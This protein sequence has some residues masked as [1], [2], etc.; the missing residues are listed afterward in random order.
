MIPGSKSTADIRQEFIYFFSSKG[1]NVIA[2]SS[3]VPDNDP[4][5]LFTNAGMNQFKDVFLGRDKRSYQRATTSQGC[6]RAGGKHN[7]L[8]NVGYTARHHTFFEMLGNFSFG[9][10]FK[11]DA[12]QFAWELLTGDK[13]FNL[14]SEK[15]WVTVYAADEE[16]YNIWTNDVGVSHE[17]ILRIGDNKGS[18]YA[19]DNFWHMG[20]TGPCGPCSEI[21]YDHGDNICGG[22]PGSMEDNGDRYVEIWNLVFTQFNRQAD[23]TLLPLR[24]PSVDTGMGLERIASVIQRVHSNYDIDLFRQLI[25]AIAEVTGAT[26]MNSQSLRVIADH[27]RSCA[28]IVSEGVVPSNEGR[29]YVLRRIIRRALRHG[30]MLGARDTFFY[31]IV[32]PLIEV[33][34][35]ATDQLKLN[36]LKLKKSMVEQV[37]RTEEKQFARTLE[38]G[39]ALLVHHE[40]GKVTGDTLD[41]EAAFRLHDTYGLPL[42]I[43][44]DVCR[45][46]NIKVDKAS[47]ERAMDTQRKRAIESRSFSAAYNMFLGLDQATHFF[48]YELVTHPGQVIALF[49]DGQ[50]VEGIHQ[51]EKAIVVL[52]DTPFY[53]ESGGQVGDR[54]EMKAA[55]GVFRVVDTLQDGKVF[56]HLGML[57]YGEFKVG[58]Q[59]SAH[60]DQA[61]RYRI[62]INHSATHLL[63]TALLQ[64]L[65]E[66][67]RIKASI[68]YELYLRVE[69]SYHQD[70][71]HDNILKL[72]DIVNKQIRRN[73]PIMTE[74]IA[75][76]ICYMQLYNYSDKV[77]VLNIGEF[78]SELCCGTHAS[79]TGDLGFFCILYEESISNGI[80]R[81]EAIT[82]EVALA[83]LHQQRYFMRTIAILVKGNKQSLVS[84]VRI[85]QDN[86]LQLREDIL[87]LK[88]MLAAQKNAALILNV[89]HFHGVQVLVS[90]LYN[91][92]NKIMLSIVGY[93]QKMLLSAVIIIAS[94]EKGCKVCLIAGVTHDLTYILK[95]D[96]IISSLAQ[97]VIGKGGGRPDIAQAACSYAASFPYA[98]ACVESLLAENLLI[99]II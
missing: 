10:Y 19:S 78:S 97:Q 57:S 38:R 92:S 63:H 87:L 27:I 98:L 75:L 31:R 34:D 73:F 35:G 28:F 16:A 24:K 6:V 95:A 66:N 20:D 26:D 89:L 53:G 18:A 82:G 55:T 44:A 81:I 88:N 23:G 60:V 65:G 47:F 48:G 54:G 58:A 39:L 32:A 21:F 40:L 94:V 7:D 62:T 17:R 4:T 72:E 5:L 8:E 43:T 25:A 61:S 59:V 68:V 49:L 77:R 1:H 70:I 86:A 80:R 29:G 14:P 79:R 91:I 30:N 69:L 83:L 52:D 15:L 12:I 22:L 41:G 56:V 42:Y 51:G 50:P 90:L 74:I 84:K 2:S 3:L 96:Y 37:F 13:W 9:D 11:Y 67:V 36:Q 93:L 46:R 33:M 85:L 64:V 76:S 45:E 99:N 71:L